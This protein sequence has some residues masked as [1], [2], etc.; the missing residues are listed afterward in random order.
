MSASDLWLLA[1]EYGLWRLGL[2]G[3]LSIAA[4]IGALVVGAQL[5]ERP[6]RRAERGQV[7]LFN[8]ATAATVAISVLVLYL[9]VFALFWPGAVLLVD[10]DVFAAVIGRDAG[11]SEYARLAWLTATL[12]TVGGALGAE[13]EDDDA[14]RA[15]A[16]TRSN[17]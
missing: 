3:V 4:V 9:A 7:T 5:W 17:G 10:A 13:L 15:A 12:T 16:C 2:L 6:R 8:L 14:V 1:A 11:A